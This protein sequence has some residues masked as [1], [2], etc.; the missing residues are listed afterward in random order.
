MLQW[1]EPVRIGP[2][3]SIKQYNWVIRKKDNSEI[4][5]QGTQDTQNTYIKVDRLQPAE[6]YLFEVKAIGKN[7]NISYN[8]LTITSAEESLS[9][10]ISVT[11]LPA[12]LIAPLVESKSQHEV[13]LFWKPYEKIAMGARFSHYVIKIAGQSQTFIQTSSINKKKVSGLSAGVQYEFKVQY[14]TSKGTSEYS[15][16][17]LVTTDQLKMT[18]LDKLKQSLGVPQLQDRLQKMESGVPQLQDR[19]QKMENGVPQLQDRLQNIENGVPQLQDRLQKMESG[20]PQLQ[21]EF[22]NFSLEVNSQLINMTV[23]MMWT[24]KGLK[25]T[26]YRIFIV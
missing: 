24:T 21:E 25:G 6:H 9:A 10:V 12:Q 5:G 19:L 13:F 22:S 15:D 8:D 11:T 26:S 1:A 14:V 4:V 17:L 7:A 2:N 3:V 20:V 16:P 23:A 18:K